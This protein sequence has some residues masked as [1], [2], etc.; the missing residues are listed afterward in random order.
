MT[1]PAKR[2]L[3]DTNV[4]IF[5]LRGDAHSPACE[6]LLNHIGSFLV[7]VPL[8]IIKELTVNLADDE[9]RDFYQILSLYPD[10]IELS[11]APAPIERIRSFEKS[12]CRKG[13]AVIAAHA[14]MLGV[15]T[16]ISENRQFLRTLTGLPI[17][18]V[19][20]ATALTR[21]D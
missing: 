13:D 5:G 21:L 14:E 10:C 8:Q 4:W 12:G 2:W 3:L 6:E 7:C 15:S 17:E 11:W 9:M 19:N 1:T 16:I 20:S 18:V